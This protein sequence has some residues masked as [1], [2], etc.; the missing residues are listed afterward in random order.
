MYLPLVLEY[1]ST[2]E[3]ARHPDGPI[4]GDGGPYL[5]AVLCTEY[6]VLSHQPKQAKVPLPPPSSTTGLTR[7]G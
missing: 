5:Q 7:V 3:T 6:E 2:L 1:F 4:D